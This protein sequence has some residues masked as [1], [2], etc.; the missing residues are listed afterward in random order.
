MPSNQYFVLGDNRNHSWDSRYW[1]FVPRDAVVGLPLVI[2]FSLNRPSTTD[3][4]QMPQ[5]PAST[6]A[7]DKLGL[8]QELVARVAAFA[9]W[10]RIFHVVR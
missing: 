5:E 2:Y 1:G 9:R 10:R 4:E 6:P 3:V 8:E 7:N